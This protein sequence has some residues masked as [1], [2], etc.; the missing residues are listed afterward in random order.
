MVV[1]AVGLSPEDKVFIAR[2]DGEGV[3]GEVQTLGIEIE[4]G[5]DG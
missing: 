2:C 1:A 3:N 4:G 5:V